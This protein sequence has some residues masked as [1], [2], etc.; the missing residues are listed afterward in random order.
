MYQ[1]DLWEKAAECTRAIKAAECTRAIDATNDPDRRET[2]AHLRALW[3]DLA[4]ESWGMT[5]MDVGRQVAD[6]A[7]LHADLTKAS[8]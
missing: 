8:F 6:M 2:L 4:N 7:A 3:I 1:Q 5:E